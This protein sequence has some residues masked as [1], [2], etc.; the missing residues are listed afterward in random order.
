MNS[1][2]VN[3]PNGASTARESKLRK[4]AHAKWLSRR[5][6]LNCSEMLMALCVIEI[7]TRYMLYKM[8]NS[9]RP[10]TIFRARRTRLRTA[11]VKLVDLS[12]GQWLTLREKN[13]GGSCRIGTALRCPTGVDNVLDTWPSLIWSFQFFV[14]VYSICLIYSSRANRHVTVSQV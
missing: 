8:R 13:S 4:G 9:C 12:L 10:E 1:K 5:S 11:L 7:R 6:R 3:P 14:D 2:A